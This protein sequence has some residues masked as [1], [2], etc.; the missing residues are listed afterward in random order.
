MIYFKIK[1]KVFNG[2]EKLVSLYTLKMMVTIE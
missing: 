2:I 1:L